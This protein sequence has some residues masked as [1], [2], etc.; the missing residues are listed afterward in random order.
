MNE[1]ALV[2]LTGTTFSDPTQA[3]LTATINWGDGTTTP[4]TV[5]TTNG[6]PVPTTGSVA[7]SHAY[8]Q[9]GIYSVTVTLTDAEG[10]M[11]TKSLQVTV[12]NPA[13]V[14]NAGPPQTVNVGS[15]VSLTAATFSDPSAPLLS[16]SYIA[17]V[18][19]GDGTT[20]DVNPLVSPPGTPADLGRVYDSHYYGQP[21]TYTVTVSVARPNQTP[22]TGTFQVTVNEVVPTVN[23]GPNIAAGPG[24]GKS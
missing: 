8:S 23:A 3:N 19:W 2:S 11:A 9:A 14:V 15:L 24:T 7:G 18:N 4:G 13:L 17:T 12:L 21:G 5:T 6:T 22:T 1:N 20:T 10:E 16:G